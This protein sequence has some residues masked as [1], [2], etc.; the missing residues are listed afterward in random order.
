MATSKRIFT[1]VRPARV[2]CLIHQDDEDWQ[3]N[4]LRVIE[5]FSSVWGGAHNIIV[6]TDG[7]N[8]T[9]R[10]WEILSA[11][12]AD[13]FY[14]YSKTVKDL[15]SIRSDEYDEWLH[16]QLESY[17][18]ED[19]DI[20]N[21]F[22][23]RQIEDMAVRTNVTPQL[24]P[25]FPL[26]IRERLAPFHVPGQIVHRM[27]SDSPPRFPLTPITTV[28]SGC[29]EKANLAVL[30]PSHHGLY[31]LWL[32]SVTGLINEALK[33]DLSREGS[34]HA[35]PT[36]EYSIDLVTSERTRNTFTSAQNLSTPFQ[37]TSLKLATYRSVK[38]SFLTGP[39]IVVAGESV[40]DFCLYYSIARLLQPV[41]WLPN[42]WLKS[43][44]TGGGTGLFDLFSQSLRS[45]LHAMDSITKCIFT[46][47]SLD[48]RQLEV[49]VD[50]LDR[51][52]LFRSDAVGSN[53]EIGFDLAGLF[54]R[55]LRL[56]EVGNAS[57]PT[58]LVVQESSEI[59]MFETPK[60]KNFSNIHPHEHRW[61]TDVIVSGHHL[62]R[63]PSLGEWTIRSPIL[64]SHGARI[65]AGTLSYFCPN[66]GYAG[67][68]IDTVLVRPTIF[69]P[70]PLE[71]FERIFWSIGYEAKISDKGFF[72]GQA[73]QK[74]GGLD[75]IGSFLRDPLTRQ[76]IFK[77]LDPSEHGNLRDDGCR[78][79][80][81]RRYLPFPAIS[82]LLGGD[83]AGQKASELLLSKDILYRGCIFKCSFCR[84]A[85]WFGLD[86][87]TQT[88]KC[89]RCGATQHASAENYWYAEHEPGWFYKLDE[90]VYQF[91]HHNGY[92]SCLALDSLRAKSQDSFLFTGD[93]EL[94]KSGSNT[95]K[96]EFE[97]DIVAIV[98]GDIVLGEAKKND[99][100][101]DKDIKKYLHLAV[102]VG[103]NKLA[104]ATFA[105]SWSAAT[106]KNIE[107]IIGSADIE[108]ITLTNSNLT[109]G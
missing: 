95:R 42:A 104:F 9:N 99:K 48:T 41:L 66:I 58:S 50:D 97:L 84:N 106:R 27:I 18:G 31:P 6:P 76:L 15:K 4:C 108:L 83:V 101:E 90:I 23:R 20:D 57:R 102:R 92:V 75:A 37:L 86:E 44:T 46:S 33:L 78:L 87:F 53:S 93:L 8:F 12:D 67:G 71:I 61:I 39:M 22:A 13:Y 59:E 36:S 63:N 14:Y 56:F 26:L 73:I 107:K 40:F 69:V 51:A 96:P 91:L 3:V 34:V 49:L 85:D 21:N 52:S 89:K 100:L 88:F 70:S 43:T 54:S 5:F 62:P 10:F 32:A 105:A 30:D 64:G 45:S 81:Q 80:D 47:H 77:F 94:I 103:A 82:K 17:L 98:D 2:A 72:T 109:S 68:D 35:M 74:F 55:P 38:S 28:M 19:A 11:Y 25:D 1:N 65:G 79:N 24:S 60:P 16:K 7:K 29:D